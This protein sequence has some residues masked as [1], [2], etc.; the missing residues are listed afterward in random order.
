[1]ESG[2]VAPSSI[3]LR[4]YAKAGCCT[5]FILRTLPALDEDR[6]AAGY[7]VTFS[8]LH[9]V[10]VVLTKMQLSRHYT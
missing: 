3:H 8:R 4:N 1:M 7:D 6:P 9:I 2:V 10:L 5:H